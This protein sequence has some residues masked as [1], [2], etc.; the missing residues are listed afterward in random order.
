M[1]K[2]KLSTKLIKGGTSRSKFMET[3][4]PL[5]LT[6]GFIYESAEEAEK[7]FRE[8]KERFMYSRFGNPTV[9]TF[10]KKMALLEEAEECWG[11]ATGMAALFTIFMSY[12][13]NGDRVV[14][15]RAL[16][17]SCHHIVTQI[18]PRFGI[19]VVLVDGTN[20]NEWEKALKKK[21]NIVFFETPSN[22]C[23]DLV[24][25]KEVSKL[26]HQAGALVV[27]DNVFATP[28]LQK[29]LK[30]GADIVMY[31]ATKHIDG[32]GRVLGGAILASKKFCKDFI[33]PFIRNTGP[34]LSPFNA[35]VL[36]K[37]IETL[38]LRVKQQ[39]KSAKK[40]VNYLK[41]SLKIKRIYYPTDSSFKQKQITKR[42]M[43]DGGSIISFE[44]KS[45]KEKEKKIAF[46]FL[47]NLKL[48]EISNNLGDSKTLVT[49]PETTTHHKLS[50]DEKISLRITKN[51]VRLSVGLEDST[52]IIE[53]IDNA[54][55]KAKEK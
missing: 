10:Q 5:F 34:S 25:I 50:S 7:S 33:K 3:S 44:L 35:W 21:T 45:Q 30:H 24:D 46:S 9:E 40:I 6:S 52:D 49:H 12:L 39:T 53:D 2:K 19:E 31:S 14:S 1:N 43:L 4:D 13:N 37:G 18:L 15:S 16:F 20:L 42:Q 32:Q 17:G 8:E 23:L 29:P 54:L 41:Q 28:I 36:L 47:N 27:V 48:I 51:L 22:P 11:T 38:E 55:K 26:A